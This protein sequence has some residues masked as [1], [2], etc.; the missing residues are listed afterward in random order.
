M[1]TYIPVFSP[2]TSVNEVIRKYPSVLPVLNGFGID[3]CCGGAES[4]TSAARSASIPIEALMAAIGATVARITSN[5]A[6]VTGSSRVQ[7]RPNQAP[8]GNGER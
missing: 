7:P 1:I 4:L 8:N 6:F 3:T 2:Q 5:P